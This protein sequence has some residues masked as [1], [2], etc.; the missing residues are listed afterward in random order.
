LYQST[1]NGF[2]IGLYFPVH[3]TTYKDKIAE[4]KLIKG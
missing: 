1:K 4:N 2:L 3:F